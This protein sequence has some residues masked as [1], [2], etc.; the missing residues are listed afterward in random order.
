MK[1]LVASAGAVVAAIIAG[2]QLVDYSGRKAAGVA[3]AAIAVAV[4]LSLALILL[5]RAAKILTIARPTATDLANAEFRAGALDENR[6][7]SGQIQ[8]AGVNWILARASYLL[9]PYATVNALLTAYRNARTQSSANPDDE[10]VQRKLSELQQQIDTVEEAAHYRDM[11]SA[12]KQLLRHFRV[13]ATIFVL[14]VIL[15]SVAG[16]F[17]KEPTNRPLNPVT[18]P[19]PVRIITNPQPNHPAPACHDREGVAVGGTL[20]R[21]TVVASPTSECPAGTMVGGE[22]GVI[23]IPEFALGAPEDCN[24][25]P[26]NGK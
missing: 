26:E 13:G 1:W 11:S 2:A 20:T 14:A 9:A 17:R 6:R 10:S 8:D 5:V 22:N 12:Y 19:F 23:V 24:C 21:P 3:L 16:L 7:A 4:A 25:P 15:F 18:K